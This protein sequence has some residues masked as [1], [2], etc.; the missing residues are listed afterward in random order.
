MKKILFTILLGAAVT[1]FAQKKK[2]SAPEQTS[3]ATP[4]AAT[5]IEGKTAGMKKLTGFF[6]FYY[7]E[8]QDKI[9]L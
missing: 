8:K 9:F 7:D 1:A 2:Q 3:S 6:D 5:G 4:S